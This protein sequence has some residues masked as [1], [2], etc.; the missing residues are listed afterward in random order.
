MPWILTSLFFCWL[1]FRE[2]RSRR[3]TRRGYDGPDPSPISK[4]YLA[5]LA[6]LALSFAWPPL[7]YWHFEHFLS[8]KATELADA[9]RARVHCNT[10]FDTFLDPE[11]MSIGH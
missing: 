8:G 7:H 3:V 1:I 11:S 2:F 4:P 9:H 5:V 6:I 10:I